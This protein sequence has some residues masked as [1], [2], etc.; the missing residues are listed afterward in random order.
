MA[1]VNDAPTRF[2]MLLLA[3]TMLGSACSA[4]PAPESGE[5]AAVLFRGGQI[6]DGTG[7]P[8]YRGDVLVVGDRIARVGVVPAAE[9]PA[10]TREVDAAG[11]T[12]MPGFIDPHSHAGPGL[13]TPELRAGEPLIRQG[14]TTVMVNPDGGGDVDL[15]AQRRRFEEGGI[16]VHVA[17]MIGHGAVRREV[18][19]MEARPPTED[20]FERMAELVRA[21]MDAG[22]F[23]MTGGLYYAPG[24][25]AENDEVVRLAAEIAPFGAF[26]SHIR[27][28]S[29]YN[30]G[31]VAAVEEVI[32]VAEVQGIRGVVTHFKALGPPVWGLSREATAAIDAAR[33]RGV[34]VFADQYPYE[35]S[36]TSIVGAL[37]PRWAL[38]G[39]TMPGMP[40]PLENR[41]ANPRERARLRADML[42]ALERRGG[43]ATL[44]LSRHRADIS[45]EGRY[46]SDLAEEWGLEPIDAAL[47]LLDAG[48][49]GLVSFNMSE[50]DIAHI[51]T[52]EWTMGSSDG[53]LVSRDEGRPHPRFYGAFPR[54][55]ARY[56]REREVLTLAEAV[57]GMTSLTT[58]VF[59]MHDRGQIAAG[60]IADLLVV[61]IEEFRDAATYQDPHALAEG[62]VHALVAG[63]FAI[64]NGETTGALAGRVLTPHWLD[65]E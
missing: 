36:G 34:E 13:A 17:L 16:G 21:G 1:S 50:E 58:T 11:L 52:R 46:L 40:S 5:G 7:N 54:R 14:I 18:L 31:L 28:E 24:S 20:E 38:A 47:R 32:E 12:I 29:D 35:A 55:I 48:G 37:V 10:D 51:M 42:V 39:E 33:A 43:A 41:L 49:A 2:R 9:V 26:S 44:L 62:I 45:L 61:D 30:I 59:R 25:Y 3:G 8:W 4:A 65:A 63:V 57:R 6:L 27:D 23:G 53:G 60:R 64:E 15:A 56:V 19:G 22:A